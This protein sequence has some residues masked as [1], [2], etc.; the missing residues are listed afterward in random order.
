MCVTRTYSIR[1]FATLMV[2]FISPPRWASAKACTRLYAI[3][4]RTT[5][6]LPFCS[7]ILQPIPS[8]AASSMSVYGE[9]LYRDQAGHIHTHVRRTPGVAAGGWDPLTPGGCPLV[10][11]P[12]DE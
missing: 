8:A 10:P 1:H 6:A 4:A 5:L 11:M 12:T 9:G 7:S 2:Y 3:W